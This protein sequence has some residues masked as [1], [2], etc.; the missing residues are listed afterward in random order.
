MRESIRL[1]K[2]YTIRAK[3]KWK[4]PSEK[5]IEFFDAIL[6]GGSKVEQKKCLDVPLD[7]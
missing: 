7:L 2:R 6:P 1:R 4:K 3:M 5:M